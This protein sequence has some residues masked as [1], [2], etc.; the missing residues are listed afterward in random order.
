MSDEQIEKPVLA[1]WLRDLQRLLQDS[2]RRITAWFVAEGVLTISFFDGVLVG[3]VE[4][5]GTV[6]IFDETWSNVPEAELVRDRICTAY[7]KSAR[8]L[9]ELRTQVE[10]AAH[11]M[12][13]HVTGLDLAGGT[14]RRFTVYGSYFPTQF[15]FEVSL[16]SKS[17]KCSNTAW[18][19]HFDFKQKDFVTH[20]LEHLAATREDP[21][22]SHTVNV[23]NINSYSGRA[24]WSLVAV[25]RYTIRALEMGVSFDTV[26]EK[27][28]HREKWS[29]EWEAL[30]STNDFVVMLDT[31]AAFFQD[32]PHEWVRL[33]NE[34]LAR[35]SWSEYFQ[36]F[37]TTSPQSVFFDTYA[38]L[39]VQARAYIFHGAR[40]ECDQFVEEAY[41]AGDT[42]FLVAV[43]CTKERLPYH[44]DVEKARNRPVHF[45]ED[46][47]FHGRPR[48]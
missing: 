48:I 21:F 45:V 31:Q 42:R 36:T 34:K 8:V 47:L 26:L 9:T 5:S 23:Q 24:C 30:S 2:V 3:Y 38:V 7:E 1:A 12:S 6:C 44:I 39:D 28:K 32:N 35:A 41:F 13:M 11:A 20:L 18:K 40:D 25:N 27:K 4:A 19:F 29:R 46:F 15:Y 16:S 37:K 10:K 14:V 22:V 33:Q 43:D 17:F